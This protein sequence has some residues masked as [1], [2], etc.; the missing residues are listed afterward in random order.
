MKIC[1]VY[2]MTH[3][4]RAK[5]F[6]GVALKFKVLEGREE[7]GKCQGTTTRWQGYRQN[8]RITGV[9][10]SEKERKRWQLS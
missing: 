3:Q 5:E 1:G 2:D 4:G 8:R 9:R 7:D 10:V 6:K